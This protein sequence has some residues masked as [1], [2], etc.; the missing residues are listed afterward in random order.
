MSSRRKSGLPPLAFGAAIVLPPLSF[1]V[2]LP[3]LKQQ[4]DE[5]VFL[6][7][8]IAATLT[9]AGSF[10]LSI[11]HDRQIDEWQR[12]AARFSSQWGLAVGG[13][14]VALLL[15]LPPIHDLIVSGAAI[16]GGEPNPDR[17]LGSPHS[18]SAL[19]SLSSHKVC[20][21]RC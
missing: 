7:T 8:G 9:I 14:L 17:Q 15:V 10:A 6:F 1:L 18:R 3:W 13:G 21:Q 19:W 20:A 2:A 16:W 4:P 11:L 12:S 5:L